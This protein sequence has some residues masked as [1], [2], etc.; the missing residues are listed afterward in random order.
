MKGHC[1]CVRSFV[2]ASLLLLDK[3]EIDRQLTRQQKT[4]RSRPMHGS[5]STRE[6][7]DAAG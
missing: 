7:L 5:E 6:W 2:R 3:Y 1:V 4:L